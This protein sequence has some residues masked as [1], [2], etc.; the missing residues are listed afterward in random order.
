VVSRERRFNIQVDEQN[1][2]IK[3]PFTTGSKL[4][5]LVGKEPDTHF[6]T[7]VIV[8][9]DDIVIGLDDRVDLTAPGRERFTV[10]A[11]PC[12]VIVNTRP[13][14]VTERILT[15]EQVVQLAFDTSADN[16]GVAY[17]ITYRNGDPSKPDGSMVKGS[18]VKVRCGMIFDVD[19]TD[20]S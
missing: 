6:I 7:Q 18:S 20:R 12:E 10:V 2:T 9:A 13:R 11:K 19:R 8:G 4:L 14:N 3:G 5:A 1:F 15:F 17:T 16:D